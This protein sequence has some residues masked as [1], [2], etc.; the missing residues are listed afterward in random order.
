MFSMI[1][2]SLVECIMRVFYREYSIGGAENLPTTGATLL[3]ANHP[4]AFVDGLVIRHIAG[5]RVFYTAKSTLAKNP[6]LRL[7]I[8]GDEWITFHRRQDGP[9]HAGRNQT[10]FAECNRRLEEG[11]AVLIFPEGKSHSEPQMLPFH[12]GAARIAQ[13]YGGSDLKI[14]P[15]GLQYTDKGRFRSRVHVEFG[16]AVP[17]DGDVQRLTDRMRVAVETAVSTAPR[18]SVEP[19]T[20]GIGPAVRTLEVALLGLP[21]AA[22]GLLNGLLPYTLVDACARLLSED[23]D[24]C[25]TYKVFP[26][27]LIYPVCAL[28]QAGLVAYFLGAGAAAAYLLSLPFAW[29]YAVRYA[30]H[31]TASG[32]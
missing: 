20:S 7:L 32:E 14:V 26:A 3:V 13:A 31:L 24:H 9:D 8:W 10:A 4:N 25:A 16:P 28:L 19:A 15:V 27:Q 23:P 11:G 21:A 30:E 17:L 6:F 22:W 12:T 2:W 1:W 18:W 5:R 29:V